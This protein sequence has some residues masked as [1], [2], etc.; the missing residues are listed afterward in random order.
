MIS[1]FEREILTRTDVATPEY[2]KAPTV[3]YI[4]WVG[5]NNTVEIG[6]VRWVHTSEDTGTEK[7]IVSASPFPGAWTYVNE[8]DILNVR[9]P[10][11]M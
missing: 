3:A 10:E 4:A 6:P 1:E 8:D 7:L 9:H 2:P 11:A 5:R